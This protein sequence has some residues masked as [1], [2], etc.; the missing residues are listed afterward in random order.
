M[1]LSDA[2]AAVITAARDWREGQTGL[3]NLFDTPASNLAAAVDALEEAM[4][5]GIEMN[6][7]WREVTEGVEVLAP[8]GKWYYISSLPPWHEDD[9]TLRIGMYVK[10]K[11]VFFP[12]DPDKVVRVRISSA[13]ALQ[14]AIGLLAETFGATV[15]GSK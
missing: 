1:E 7:P 4:P 3:A 11:E 13:D 2:L 12:R 15:I 5:M 6:K 10:G 9:G 8:D 14:S